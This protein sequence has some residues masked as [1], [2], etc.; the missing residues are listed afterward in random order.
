MWAASLLRAILFR[1]MSSFVRLTPNTRGR[2]WFYD[3]SRR[4][5]FAV[6]SRGRID[7]LTADQI[8]TM[9]GYALKRDESAFVA[10]L[11]KIATTGK[12]PLIIDCG[13]FTGL[14]TKHFAEKYPQ[15]I[16]VAVE[17]D[18]GNF[19]LAQQQCAGLPNVRLIQ[20]FVGSKSGFAR[21]HNPDAEPWAFRT[22]RTSDSNDFPIFTIQDLVDR[23]ENVEMALVKV[24]IEGFESD[25]FAGNLAWIDD[26]PILIVELH[27]W[28]HP[29]ELTSQNFLKAM[30][31]RKRTFVHRGE[32][33]FST[34]MPLA[35]AGNVPK[36]GS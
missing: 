19:E 13:A 26:C 4:R 7:S 20:G 29:E 1:G 33:V 35:D 3:R 31:G 36:V 16:V 22:Q 10:R 23:E 15:A 14:S 34:L 27:D 24:D 6:R 9:D 28:L 11:E 17:P 25:L 18:A 21:I 30:A 12:R 2:I 32:N 8:F 5:V